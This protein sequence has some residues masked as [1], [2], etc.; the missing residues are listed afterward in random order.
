MLD[1]CCDDSV[2]TKPV[3]SSDPSDNF[4]E[5]DKGAV[6]PDAPGNFTGVFTRPAVHS[7]SVWLETNDCATSTVTSN[8]AEYD[9]PLTSF[10]VYTNEYGESAVLTAVVL[11]SSR[12]DSS[13]ENPVGSPDV[14]SSTNV[15]SSVPVPPDAAGN[16]TGVFKFSADHLKPAGTETSDTASLTVTAKS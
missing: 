1:N 3:G 4:N 12:D 15:Y 7:S 5:Y 8:V 2:N 14:P 6:P 13:N 10:T 9:A 11:D 16:A